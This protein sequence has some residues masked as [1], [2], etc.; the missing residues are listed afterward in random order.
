MAMYEASRYGN[1]EIVKLMLEKGAEHFKLTQK[2]ALVAAGLFSI[3]YSPF[4]YAS[5]KFYGDP[6]EKGTKEHVSWVE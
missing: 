3:L 4:L 1:M 5:Y 6:F 2:I